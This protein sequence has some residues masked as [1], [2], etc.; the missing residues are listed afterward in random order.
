ME[1][2]KQMPLFF[3]TP[4]R[5]SSSAPVKFSIAGDLRQQTYNSTMTMINILASTYPTSTQETTPATALLIAGDMSYANS[6]QP[7]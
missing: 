5:K 2:P 4:P 6:I 7:Q 1:L 3:F